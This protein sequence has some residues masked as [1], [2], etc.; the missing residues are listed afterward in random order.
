MAHTYSIPNLA[1]ACKVLKWIQLDAERPVT[2]KAAST[3]VK[4]PYTT[5]FRI[6][7][8]LA[9]EGFLRREND[10]YGLGAAL[11]PLGLGARKTIGI[12]NIALPHLQQLSIDVGETV[13][14]AILNE[15]RSMILEVVYGTHP[16]SATTSR[17]GTLVDLHCSATGKIF[18]TWALHDRIAEFVKLYKPTKR[19]PN[20]LTTAAELIR[21]CAEIRKRGYAID[22]EEYFTGVRCIGAPVFGPD[23]QVIAAVGITSSVVMLP[24]EN[25]PRFS[26]KLLATTRRISEQMGAQGSGRTG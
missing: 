23:L 16:L 21:D 22:E 20:T 15:F 2:V 4:I 24:L 3:A 5:C 25:L 1:K 8:T 7:N 14:L 26:E 10:H 18:L 6:M 12:R 19:T 17:P 9:A 13:Q 11:I